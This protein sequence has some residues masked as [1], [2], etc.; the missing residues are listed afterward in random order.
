MT[1]MPILLLIPVALA[2]VLGVG[3][4]VPQARRL[5]RQRC[6]AGVSPTW[7]GVGVAIN[8]G[9]VLYA[10]Q[11][12]VYGLLPVSFGS[13]VLYLVMAHAMRAIDASTLTT[14]SL[15]ALVV[16]NLLAWS[17]AIDGA[18]ALGL[19]LAGLYTVQFAP[20]ALSAVRSKDL[21]GV[22]PSTWVMAF[23][24]AILWAGYGAAIA[25]VAVFLGGAGASVMS[26]IV[27][28]RLAAD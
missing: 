7:I 14:A 24:E 12:D 28:L 23:V 20:A 2:N 18:G 5:A 9:W 6:L 13:L 27:L 17:M 15:A 3:M 22:A 8:A 25:D 1:S 4:L 19:T 11:R 21:A 10:L 26:L 16:S